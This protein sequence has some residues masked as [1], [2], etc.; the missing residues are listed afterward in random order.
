MQPTIVAFPPECLRRR[1]FNSVAVALYCAQQDDRDVDG[2]LS[3]EPY[4]CPHCGLLH[5]REKAA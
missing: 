4:T 3:T 2:R 5:L 1:A